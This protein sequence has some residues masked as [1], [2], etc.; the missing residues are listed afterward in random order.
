MYV[1]NPDNQKR[2]TTKYFKKDEFFSKYRLFGKVK[3]LE[4]IYKGY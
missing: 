3:K 4:R 2:I 1:I